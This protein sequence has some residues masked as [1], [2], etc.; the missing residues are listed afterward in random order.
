MARVR[1]RKQQNFQ[2]RKHTLLKKAYELGQL[3]NADIAFFIYKAGRYFTYRSTDRP[4][5]PPT[6][7]EIVSTIVR[8]T[9]AP[10]A[11]K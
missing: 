10:L 6:W 8:Y 4:S 2:R 7:E 9:Y 3:G 11:Q 1:N 5:W